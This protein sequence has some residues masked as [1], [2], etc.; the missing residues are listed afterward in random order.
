MAWYCC[1][2]G[3]TENEECVISDELEGLIS[4]MTS[5]VR[6]LRPRCKDIRQI[7]QDWYFTNVASL[8]RKGKPEPSTGSEGI[9]EVQGQPTIE[10][11]RKWK[12][13]LIRNLYMALVRKRQI[14]TEIKTEA[15]L[16]EEANIELLIDSLVEH[17]YKEGQDLVAQMHLSDSD[18]LILSAQYCA[19]QTTNCENLQKDTRPR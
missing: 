18:K 13:G 12:Q 9:W 11:W 5:E 6:E 2:F 4:G 19:L 1:D 14:L 17:R 8:T 7:C 15:D 10:S 3:L 16:S